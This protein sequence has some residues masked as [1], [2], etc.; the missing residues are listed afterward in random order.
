[1]EK[2]TREDGKTLQE[3]P[4][5]E[6]VNSSGLNEL[7]NRMLHEEMNYNKQELKD[8]NLSIFHNMSSE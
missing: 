6:I 8:E 1:M 2:L 7:G 4:E 5:I 3:Y